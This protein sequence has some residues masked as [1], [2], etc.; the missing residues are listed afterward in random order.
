MM[1]ENF[2]G[3][4]CESF[5]ELFFAVEVLLRGLPADFLR[6]VFLEWERRLWVCCESRAEYV[7]QT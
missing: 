5:D 1:K 6:M 7:E 4:R 2:S 3:Q